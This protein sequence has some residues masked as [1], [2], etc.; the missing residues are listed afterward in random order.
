MLTHVKP[1]QLGCYDAL[2]ELP[3]FRERELVGMVVSRCHKLAGIFHD[4]VSK[5]R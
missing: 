1:T 2:E 3:C 5:S 4:C